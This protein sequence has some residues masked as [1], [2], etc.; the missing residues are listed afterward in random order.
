MIDKLKG[1]YGGIVAY[2]RAIRAEWKR[3]TWPTPAELRSSTVIVVVTLVVITSYM[4]VVDQILLE[5]FKRFVNVN[6]G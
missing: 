6:V 1:W 5:I 4:W 3:V 2:L